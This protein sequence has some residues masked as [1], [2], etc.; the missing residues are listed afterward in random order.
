MGDNSTAQRVGS[1]R[2]AFLS[3]SAI[4]AAGIP[5]LAHSAPAAANPLSG[6]KPDPGLRDML[7]HVDPRRIEATLQRLVSFGTRH[8]ASSQTDPVR[9]IGAATNWVY[10]Q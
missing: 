6:S 9:G 3:A 5:V 4:A 10:S 7:K 1:T 8:T 2:R